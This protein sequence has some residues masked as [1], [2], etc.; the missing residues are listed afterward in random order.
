ME[1]DSW[2]NLVD[3]FYH[4]H[5]ELGMGTLLVDDGNLALTVVAVEGP[6]VFCL[7][8]E[9]GTVSNNKGLS[10]PGVAEAYVDLVRDL[11]LTPQMLSPEGRERLGL[12]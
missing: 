10:L 1:K 2:L 3:S 8:V 11:P 6:D 5:D 7:V 12:D 4:V 9:G